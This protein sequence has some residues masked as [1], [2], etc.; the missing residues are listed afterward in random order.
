MPQI[1]TRKKQH[2]CFDAAI[3]DWTERAEKKFGKLS[4]K[5]TTEYLRNPEFTIIRRETWDDIGRNSFDVITTDGKNGVA[6]IETMHAKNYTN[7]TETFTVKYLD[8]LGQEVSL[9]V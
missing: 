9:T 1:I 7:S 4:H 3:D 2:D 8:A 6:T 5:V